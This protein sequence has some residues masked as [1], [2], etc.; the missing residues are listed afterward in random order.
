M[1]KVDE[2]MSFLNLNIGK[3]A[4]LHPDIFDSARKENV[5][6][7]DFNTVITRKRFATSEG[8]AYVK[9]PIVMGCKNIYRFK[10]LASETMS[11]NIG[12]E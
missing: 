12:L 4:V 5:T 10:V 8:I 3:D 6:I 9:R 11:I 1:K 2:E 7:S